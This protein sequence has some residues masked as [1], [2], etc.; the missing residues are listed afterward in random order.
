MIRTHRHPRIRTALGALAALMLAALWLAGPRAH[1]APHGLG[2]VE[3]RGSGGPTLVLIPE[4]WASWEVW[5][6]FMTRNA[7]RYS[8]LA[9]TPPGAAGS[10]PP[11][12]PEEGGSRLAAF[13]DA[14]L[15]MLDEAG[16]DRPILVGHS[17]GGLV[18]LQVAIEHPDRVAGVISVDGPPALPIGQEM[19]PEQRARFIE[20]AI[21]P[22]IRAKPEADWRGAVAKS[23]KQAASEPADIDRI[24]KMLLGTDGAVSAEYYLAA[25]KTDLTPRL[26][27]LRV[28]ALFLGAVGDVPLPG[29]DRD[30]TR[31][32]WQ[33]LAMKGD[34]VQVAIFEATR[35]YIMLDR[36]EAFDAAIAAF[37]EGRQVEGYTPPEASGPRWSDPA[38]TSPPRIIR[39]TGPAKKQGDAPEPVYIDP[40]KPSGGR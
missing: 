22:V 8:M 38:P 32:Y 2:H 26:K 37:V 16:I 36:P 1:A 6:E 40:K 39:D 17:W 28:P 33:S 21:A 29:M 35:Q 27:S 20:T 3:A 4:L 30:S 18:A 7:S 19:S 11:P 25:A 12:A 23:A 5:D 15:A 10:T 9:V 24:E 31:A 14:L 34:R 13:G